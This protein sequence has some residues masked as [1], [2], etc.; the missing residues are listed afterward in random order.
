[1]HIVEC[2]PAR[3]AHFQPC[4]ARARAVALAALAV[5]LA[6][7]PVAAASGN[8]ARVLVVGQAADRRDAVGQAAVR[9]LR[10]E[11]WTAAA[12]GAD[13]AVSKALRACS[14]GTDPDACRQVGASGAAGE[15]VLAIEVAGEVGAQVALTGWLISGEGELLLA[16]RR[17]CAPCSAQSLE[18]TV[19]DLV[20]VLLREKAGSVS[21]SVIRIRSAPSGARVLVD[22]EPV[23][24]TALDYTVFPGRHRITIDKPG[25]Q[26]ELR[27]VDAPVG[28]TID[29]DVV[30][31]RSASRES[32]SGGRGALPWILGGA[33]VAALA[34][35]ATLI[36]LDTPKLDEDG[37][38]RPHHRSSLWPGVA[39][40]VAG[41]AL[42]GSGV[43]LLLRDQEPAKPSSPAVGLHIDKGNLWIVGSGQF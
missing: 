30:L 2:E 10:D 37:N 17:Y 24:V 20:G 9:A 8:T 14:D 23:G 38:Y 31:E 15:H 18:A 16:E 6:D 12:A 11:G 21:R 29:V 19:R 28:S 7:A 42:V 25:Y 33:G 13:E 39:T 40:A 26:I 35:G 1:M 4:R 34:G 5:L 32:G 27:E 36:V 22:G 3:A 43:W 41:S